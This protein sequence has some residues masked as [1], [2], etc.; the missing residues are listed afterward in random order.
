MHEELAC[1]ITELVRRQGWGTGTRLTER[2]LASELKVSRTPIRTALKLLEQRGVVKSA[3]SRGYMVGELSGAE[4]SNTNPDDLDAVYIRIASDRLSGK[5]NDRISES[6]LMRRYDLPRAS[7]LKIVSRIASEGWIERLPGHGW[8]FSPM[9]TSDEA[10]LQSFRFRMINEPAAIL[11]PSF[12]LNEAALRDVRA[13]Q[14]A[15]VDG[16]LKCA[17]SLELFQINNRLHETIAECSN[18]AFLIESI[19]KINRLR[20]LMELGVREERQA[21]AAQCYEHVKILDLL[22]EGRRQDAADMMRL[23][24]SLVSTKKARMPLA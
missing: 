4:D 15:L 6:Q 8:E 14:V 13:Q 2:L 16:D 1:G 10:Y 18:N 7:M 9:L 20:R 23:H 22:L 21:S 24:L 17:G 12:V 11:E 19:K 3:G 5:L